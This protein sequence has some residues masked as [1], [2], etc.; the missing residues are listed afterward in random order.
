MPSV[1]AVIAVSTDAL[2]SCCIYR[3]VQAKRVDLV[4]RGPIFDNRWALIESLNMRLKFSNV[5]NIACF[6]K[7]ALSYLPLHQTDSGV[8]SAFDQ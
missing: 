7:L 5:P 3:I 8:V 1:A 6:F 2:A 4:E